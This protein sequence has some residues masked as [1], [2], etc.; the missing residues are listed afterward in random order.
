M[1]RHSPLPLTRVTWS[2][3]GQGAAEAEALDS[4]VAARIAAGRMGRG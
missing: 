4:S 2:G 3:A 1:I